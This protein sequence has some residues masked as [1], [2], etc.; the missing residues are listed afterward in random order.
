MK[1]IK[2]FVPVLVLLV[3]SFYIFGRYD[4]LPAVVINGIV[5]LPILLAL[6]V[7]GL[8]VHFNRSPVFFYLLL[9]VISNVVLGLGLAETAL[10]YAVM[11]FF[12]PLLLLVFTLIPE[13][14]VF[15]VRALPG[16]AVLLTSIL[17]FMVLTINAPGWASQFLLND[18][19]PARYFDWSR[20]PQTV[21]MS[22]CLVFISM[23]VLNFLRSSTHVAAG[24]GILIMLLAQFHVGDTSA[25]LN[26]FSSAALLMCLY[27][28]MQE[29]WR[30]AYLD[31][32]TELPARRALREK[33][34]KM[35][36]LYSVAMVDVDHFKKFNDT[37]GHDTGDAVLRM[38]AAKLNKVTGSGST[39]R[40]GGEE[41]TIVFSGKGVD[42]VT[43]HL[44]TVREKIAASPFVV[45]RE[46]RRLSDGQAGRRQKKSVQVTVSV[47]VADSNSAAGSP[48]EI[49]KLA[50]KA[51]YRAKKQGRNQVCN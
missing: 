49:M 41:F 19:L 23:L 48:W 34:Q 43:A 4:Q 1:I 18:W 27:A 20:L 32:L 8:S 29:S 25:S 45:N 11:A 44:E 46:G 12:I 42:D 24:L 5:F 14:G 22:G 37:Y 31:E 2:K 51:L 3:L 15:S 13:R 16:Y 7:L 36:G 10:S 38:I 39:Y 40:Y 26:V 6:T 21:L 30:M 50:D 35:G 47:G 28:V 9:I 17:S 33:F